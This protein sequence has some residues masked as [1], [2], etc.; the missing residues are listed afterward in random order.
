MK[1]LFLAYWKERPVDA[2][3]RS[4]RAALE[5]CRDSN[6]TLRRTGHLLAAEAC[7]SSQAATTIRV[8]GGQ[9]AVTDG[10]YAD[11]REQLS[12]L[13]VI[14]AADLNEAIRLA[15]RM[16][17]AQLGPIEVRPVDELRPA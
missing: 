3:S 4:E 14:D 16:P 11:T 6:D 9:V 17:Q 1:Y 2:L 7:Q 13:Y 5:E 8:Q 15:S 12:G 10:P